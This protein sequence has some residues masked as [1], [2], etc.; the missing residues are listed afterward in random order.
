MIKLII[1]FLTLFFAWGAMKLIDKV[2][3]SDS[4]ESE[5]KVEK[6]TNNKVNVFKYGFF[7]TLTILLF[8][9]LFGS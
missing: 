1:I 8:V 9:L 5:K 6:E 4:E 7:I 3:I 2:C